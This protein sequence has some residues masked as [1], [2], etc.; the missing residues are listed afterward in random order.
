LKINRSISIARP[1]EEVFAFVSDVRND[2]QW[3]TDIRAARLADGETVG[4]GAVFQIERRQ[5][6]RGVSEGTF[7]VTG[8]DPPRRVI[9]DGRLGDFTAVVTHTVEPDGTGS[10]F[11]KHVEASPLGIMRVLGPLMV[12]MMNRETARHLDNLKSVLESGARA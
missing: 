11:T 3:H 9:L 4:P 2:P 6:F 8:Y 10:R 12:P 5:P 7:T 1:P